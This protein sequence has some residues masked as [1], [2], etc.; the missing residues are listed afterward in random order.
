MGRDNLLDAVRISDGKQVMLK[1]IFKS[2]HPHEADIA[3]MFSSPELASDPHNHCVSLFDVLQDPDDEDVIFL[4]QPFLRA[5]DDPPLDTIG[6]VVEFLRQIFE[7]IHFMHTHHVAH[8]DCMNLNIMMDASPIY[9]RGYHPIDQLLTR[10]YASI[11]KPLTRTEHPT[12]YYIID[13]GLSHQ[14]KPDDPNPIV[15][16]VLSGDK[17]VPEFQDSSCFSAP[18][19]PFPTDVYYLGNLVRED[20]FERYYGLDFLKP[21]V[22]DMVR[23]DP[24]KRPTMEEVVSRFDEIRAT[25]KRWKLRG[26][27]VAR[28]ENN[29]V[30]LLKDV[31][32]V[33]RTAKFIVRRYPPVP[34]P[35]SR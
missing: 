21:L 15:L 18:Q 16:P 1:K 19:N 27:L 28:R 30:K 31:R 24:T 3:K 6:E 7:G 11:A 26:R 23:D 20:F 13:F 8:R 12:Q 14:F 33:F 17:T 5:Y 22:M 34:T 35:T 32:H 29:L 4:V 25:L 10:D 9:P 2:T